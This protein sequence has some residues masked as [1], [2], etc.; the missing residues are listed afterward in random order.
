M[1][2]EIFVRHQ[3]VGGVEQALKLLKRQVMREGIFKVLQDH[4]CYTKPGDRVRRKRG[5]AAARRRK[6]ARMTAKMIERVKAR[7]A[8]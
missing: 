5:R 1:A 8:R 2:I 7:G 4:K 3:S 6:S